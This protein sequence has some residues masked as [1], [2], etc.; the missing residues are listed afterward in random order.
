M[1]VGRP[2][3]GP[4]SRREYRGQTGAGS[5]VLGPLAKPANVNTAVLTGHALRINAHPVIN[6]IATPGPADCNLS[7]L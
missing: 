1:R 7:V 2:R 6:W 3:S 4:I 5:R